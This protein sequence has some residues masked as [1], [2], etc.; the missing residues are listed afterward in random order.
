MLLLYKLKE[1]EC[2]LEREGLESE[3]LVTVRK[4]KAL[5]LQVDFKTEV[6]ADERLEHLQKVLR[7]LKG[8]ELSD[9]EASLLIEILK[10][11]EKD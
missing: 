3:Q 8:Q 6:L 1:L 2:L 4:L 5:L 7:E 10:E 9:R 11:T